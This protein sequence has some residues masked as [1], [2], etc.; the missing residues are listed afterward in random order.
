MPL[1][2][3]FALVAVP[4]IAPAN[5]PT[6]VVAVTVPPKN[7]PPATPTPPATCSAPVTAE[8]TPVVPVITADTALTFVDVSTN[9]AP[10]TDRPSFTLNV[11]SSSLYNQRITNRN[12]IKSFF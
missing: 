1:V 11:M 12:L 7:P 10:L 5:D 6:N 2:K 8:V 9:N 3:L 4:E